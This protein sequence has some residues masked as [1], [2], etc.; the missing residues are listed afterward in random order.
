M[1]GIIG[2]TGN[3]SGVVGLGA[4]MIKIASG[5]FT[6]ISTVDL[7]ADLGSYLVH[8]VHLQVRRSDGQIGG[9]QMYGRVK[10]G[11]SWL[12]S[13]VYAWNLLGMY[14]STQTTYHSATDSV[15]RM[16][17]DGLRNNSLAQ[18]NITYHN[19]TNSGGSNKATMSSTGT[20]PN[21]DAD[22]RLVTQYATGHL[23]NTTAIEDL[24]YYATSG[25]LVGSWQLYGIT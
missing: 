3:R 12:T 23:N 1:S 5:T 13:G 15:W 14:Q 18:F 11:G 17:R 25:T 8:Q 16:T 9:M 21:H 4:A 7:G 19:L 20:G 2:E 6:N 22:N 10:Q 24:R